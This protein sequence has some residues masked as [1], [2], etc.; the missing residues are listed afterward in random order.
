MCDPI[1]CAVA[2]G[3]PRRWAGDAISPLFGSGPWP[4]FIPT[5]VNRITN[6]FGKLFLGAFVLYGKIC[7]RYAL[8]SPVEHYPRQN[9]SGLFHKFRTFSA[10]SLK[11]ADTLTAILTITLLAMP[12]LHPK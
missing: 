10:Y 2:R 12:A 5:K 4:C 3:L 9:R 1:L 7:C 8:I 11:P 6:S